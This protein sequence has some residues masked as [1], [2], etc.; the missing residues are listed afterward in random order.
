LPLGALDTI[1]VDCHGDGAN[2][3]QSHVLFSP[4]LG[5]VVR[6]ESAAGSRDLVAIRP[7][8]G[9][10][11]SAARLGLDWAL[12]HALEQ[13]IANTPVQWSSTAVAPHFEIRA[14]A[15][16]SGQR[17]GLSGKYGA[18]LCRRYDLT[19]AGTPSLSYPGIACQGEGGSWAV[20]GGNMVLASPAGGINAHVSA[21]RSARN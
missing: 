15:S 2:P 17:A 9:D 7:F 19:Q 16:L 20:P 11:P 13:P 21:Q 14:Q 4:R 5:V 3:Q 12:T 8:T 10:W 6:Q 1:A 18:Q